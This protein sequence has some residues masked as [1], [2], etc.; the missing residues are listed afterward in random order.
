MKL[1]VSQTS[2][3]RVCRT[4]YSFNSE[5]Q[6]TASA[7]R[8]SCMDPFLLELYFTK[9]EFVAKYLLCC[10]DVETL[11]MK[12]ILSLADD[13][14][15]HLWENCILGYTE[16]AGLPLLRDEIR[17]QYYPTLPSSQYVHCFCGAEEA[18]YATLKSLLTPQDEVICITPCYQSLMSIPASIG[19]RVIAMDLDS[20]WSLDVGKLGHILSSL[21]N[22][23]MIIIN[24]PHNPTGALIN[25][26]TLNEIIALCR[27][28]NL[29]LF[30]D[31]VYRGLEMSPDRILPPACT[32]YSKAI[33][34]GVVSKSLGLAGLRIGW[35]ATQDSSIL[36]AAAAFKHYLSI[37]NS[38]PSEILALIAI[39]N[40]ERIL[41]R[42]RQIMLTNLSLFES[43][44]TRHSALFEWTPPKGGCVAFV[45][46]KASGALPL[47]ALCE[48]L[49]NEFG[50]L[51]LPGSQFPGAEK[52][53]S[54]YFRL[55]FGRS[56]FSVALMKLEEALE[57][58]DLA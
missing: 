16:T 35:I 17:R 45:R 9:Y 19:A 36:A 1:E 24:Y 34:L 6:I 20:D 22:C 11:S 55:G 10:S 3:E 49:V 5:F 13:E 23:R 57:I 44:L 52:D 48:R 41:S 21:T 51:L 27:E 32:L 58:I 7:I 2:V 42:N 39:R 38:A 12:E 8:Q 43:F 25:L 54:E 30:L 14:C 15:T 31:E 46:Y 33:S 18:I 40:N 4:D 47:E 56:N 26:S 50:I 29:Y 28:F 37:C 53:F